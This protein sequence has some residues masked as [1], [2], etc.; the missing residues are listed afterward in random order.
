[1]PTGLHVLLSFILSTA[2]TVESQLNQWSK[3]SAPLVLRVQ[4]K[5][6][7]LLITWNP[8]A[9]SSGQAALLEVSDG[10]KRLTWFISSELRSVTY[11]RKADDTQLRLSLNS[12]TEVVRCLSSQSQAKA[13][14]VDDE[15]EKL[16]RDLADVR[17]LRTTIQN[18]NGRLLLLQREALLLLSTVGVAGPRSRL[19]KASASKKG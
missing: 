6:N 10:P 9:V 3:P 16:A 13:L 15:A 19:P 1:M 18:Q 8:R 17:A 14:P 4:E 12:Q 11:V 5:G 7:Q 2:L